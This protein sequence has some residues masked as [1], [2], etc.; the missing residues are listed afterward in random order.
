VVENVLPSG[1]TFT[2]YEGD[3]TTAESEG[4]ITKVLARLQIAVA[5][6]TNYEATQTLTTEIDLRNR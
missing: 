2:F 6:G 3:G 1:L 4:E 5:Q